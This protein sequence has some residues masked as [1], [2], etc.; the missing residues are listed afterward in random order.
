MAGLKVAVLA[1]LKKNAPKYDGMPPDAWADLDSEETMDSIVAAL[2][3]GGHDAFFLEADVSLYDRLREVKPDIC[4]NLS[5]GHFGESREAHIPAI[6]EMLRIPY[7]CSQVLTLALTLDKPMTKRVLHYHRLPTPEFQ[8]FE[9][10]KEPLDDDMRFP[11]FVKPSREG[12][13]MGVSAKSIVHDDYE[14]REQLE[15]QLA[16]YQQP[17]LVERYIPGREVTVGIVGNLQA[18]VAWRLPEPTTAK[19]ATKGLH[20]FPIL[21]PDLTPFNEQEKGLYSGHLKIDIPEQL[22]YL[23]PAPLEPEQ[24]D[25]LNRLAAATFRVTGAMDV[26]RVDFRLDETQGFKPYILEINPLPGMNAEIS[27]IV[28]EARAE[29]ISHTELVNMVLDEALV[30]YG[31]D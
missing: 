22:T 11:L 6:L 28:I 5:E 15:E 13:G 8:V 19:R 27:D 17:I 7:T 26:A 1:N 3:E 2:R 30:R 24:A 16:R 4:F 29:G 23:C 18:P 21:E 20:F 12:T 10:L 14:L 25:E 9:R 31:M